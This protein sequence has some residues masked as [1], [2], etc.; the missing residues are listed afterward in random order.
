LKAFTF[1]I[2]TNIFIA[3]AA[4]SLAL[5]SQ[6]ELGMHPQFHAYLLVIFFAALFDYS[7]HRFITLHN[8]PEAL[9]IEKY[10]WEARHFSI[11]KSLIIL[12]LIGLGISLLFV[13]IQIMYLLV[14]LSIL[15]LL[16]SI[17]IFKKNEV[18]FRLQEI[19]GLKIF[20]IAFVWSATTVLIPVLQSENNI[21]NNQVL[22]VFIERFTFIVAV[23]IP[24]DI[25]DMKADKLSGFRTVPIVLGEIKARLISNISLVL[26]LV[27]AIVHYHLTRQSFIIPFYSA[28]IALNYYFI[29]N[30]KIRNRPLYYHG[31]L[32]GSIIIHGLLIFASQFLLM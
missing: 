21:R 10:N 22:L 26:S 17:A 23:A 20:L 25:R 13:R 31:I 28:S 6:A 24:F 2:K 7:F 11:L 27:I 9:R 8:K 3:F 5:A 30:K 1:I 4:V 16:Y 15:T 18:R 12:S 14:P 19:P 29:N 32:D